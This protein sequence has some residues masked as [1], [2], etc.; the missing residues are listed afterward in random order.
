[1]RTISSGL[2]TELA[3]HSQ[4]PIE[5]VDLFFGSQLVDDSSTLH[6]A[7]HDVPVGFFNLD[8]A[9][10]TYTPIGLRRSG[11]TNIIENEQRQVSLA[12]DNLNRTFQAFFFQNADFMRDKRIVLRHVDGNALGNAANAVVVMDGTVSVVRITERACE[13]E[14]GGSLGG[15]SFKPGWPLDR[16]CSL[17]FAETICA[18]GVSAATLL[19]EQT[20]TLAS[21]STKT[22]VR[23]ASVTRPDRYYA[24]GTI[25]FLTGQNA[26]AMRK[27]IKWTQS[28]KQADLDFGLPYTP[29]VGDSVTI[30][31]DCDKTINECR[32]R[33][34]EINPVSGNE[35]NFH[36]FP[37]V[38]Q[39]INT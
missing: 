29:T 28:T 16:I 31:R 6:Y 14:L 20:D 39:S 33:Y 32:S 38:T 24:L 37:T 10:K 17:E 22:A 4:Y 11:V 13:L 25:S 12:L 19:Q 30:R 3:K 8:G 15:L 35:A 9:A 18:R 5:L 23:L 1:M 26:G 34:T 2:A 21:G 27:I 36:G 7:I